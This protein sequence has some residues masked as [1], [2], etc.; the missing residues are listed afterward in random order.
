MA[1]VVAFVLRTARRSPVRACMSVALLVAITAGCA[2]A[3]LA[4]GRR[5]EMGYPRLLAAT[6][7][8][9][10]LVFSGS[11]SRRRQA[12]NAAFRSNATWRPFSAETTARRPAVRMLS[13]MPT[14]QRVRPSAPLVST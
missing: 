13:S 6:Y 2:L 8:P 5:T 3:A 7:A 14:P 12:T 1:F 10:A 9:H 11:R 4:A